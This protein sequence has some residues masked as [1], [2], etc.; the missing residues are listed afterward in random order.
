MSSTPLPPWTASPARVSAETLVSVLRAG[1]EPSRLR[2]LALLAERELT[3]KDLTAILGQSQPRIS[4][5][6][7]LLTEAGLVDRFPEGSWVYYRRSED[8]TVA[9]VV[10]ALIAVL[11]PE[12][13]AI[14][15]DRARLRAVA[16][17]HVARTEAYF[18]AHARQWGELR[19][20]HVA[21]DEVEAALIA[22]LGETRIDRLV[23]LG[24]GTG[25]MLTLL[26]GRYERAIGID[27]SHEM[28]QI[29]RL[30]IERAGLTDVRVQQ[31]DVMAPPLPANGAD[32]VTIHQVLHYLDD[33]AAALRVAARLLG[34]GGRLL[35]VDFAP[36]GL[37]LL[38]EA[39]AHRRLGFSD[40]EMRRMLDLAGLDLVGL[41]T[42]PPPP[43]G[44]PGDR[45]T[46]TLWLARDRRIVLARSTPGTIA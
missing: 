33:P 46:V 20:L 13:P 2:I 40:E 31:G 37:E 9:A 3:V 32:L 41:R 10:G 38:R 26:A 18:A 27:A 34:P 39:H 16:E 35:I 25:R 22:T 23:D 43:G 14:A 19:R 42:L 11:D 24:T 21:E 1:G 7:K 15:G 28:L 6:L 30:E 8:P 12:D 4:R 44:A 5:H 36:H 17:E 45:L 29:A